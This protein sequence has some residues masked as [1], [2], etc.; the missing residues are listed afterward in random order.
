MYDEEKMIDGI[1]H[2][3][4]M[5]NSEFRPLGLKQL[6]L[7]YQQLKIKS[8][9]LEETTTDLVEISNEELIEELSRRLN[10]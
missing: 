8:Q 3:R 2:F 9:F 5:P 1:M 10:S 7:R 6:S 4:T